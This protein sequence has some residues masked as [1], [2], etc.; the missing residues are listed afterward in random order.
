VYYLE[1]VIIGYN[2]DFPSS[3]VKK[4]EF[5]EKSINLDGLFNNMV[6]F[7]GKEQALSGGINN[8]SQF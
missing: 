6:V 8:I 4:V 5:E 2:M 3:L 7:E 1:Q